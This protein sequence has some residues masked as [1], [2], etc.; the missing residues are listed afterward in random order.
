MKKKI[1]VKEIPEDI[2]SSSELE[3]VIFSYIFFNIFN[4][5]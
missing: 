2:L 4:E 3:E 5:D 1:F